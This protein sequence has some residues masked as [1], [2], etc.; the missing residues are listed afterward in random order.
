MGSSHR[1][2]AASSWKE[3]MVHK[4]APGRNSMQAVEWRSTAPV[5]R[6]TAAL[7]RTPVRNGPGRPAGTR[8]WLAPSRLQWFPSS[9]SPA[10]MART[11]PSGTKRALFQ[12]TCADISAGE[13]G[14]QMVRGGTTKS[15]SSR[16]GKQE[17][18]ETAGAPLR[19]VAFSHSSSE[20]RR[21][22]ADATAE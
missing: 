13:V 21:A 12:R 14:G 8:H 9:A 18:K 17:L 20:P 1:L 10:S 22:M 19:A 16:N 15:I 4:P 7:Q 2:W 6:S 11:T 5:R 3:T